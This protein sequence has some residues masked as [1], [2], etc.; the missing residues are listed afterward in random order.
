MDLFKSVIE[1]E[2]IGLKGFM[3]CLLAA[4]VAGLAI[5][6]IHRFK[7]NCSQSFAVTLALL[8]S[9]VAV[10]ILLVNGNIG[11]GIA[12]A[13]AF[14]LTRFRSQPGTGKEICSIFF[15]M[16]A[17]LSCGT[18]YVYICAI[19]LVVIGALSILYTLIG[20]G[21]PDTSIREM[22]VLIPEN[23]DYMEIF[24][25]LFEKYLKRY[26]LVKVR[27]TNMG[28]MYRLKYEIVFKDE[29]EQ[30]KLMDEIRERNGNLE[31]MIG[32]VEIDTT[33]I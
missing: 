33:S 29:K 6:F 26:D 25:D 23:L 21:T 2:G 4:V 11:T 18:G 10:I 13:G 9:M 31:V 1:T 20:F 15:A 7:T 30:K 24:D 16:V 5:S 22:T 17:G 27:T 8:P 32:R 12:V 28:S 3:I 19:F 14:S